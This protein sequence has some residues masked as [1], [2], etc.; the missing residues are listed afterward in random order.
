MRAILTDMGIV[1]NETLGRGKPVILLPGWLESWDGWRGTMEVLCDHYRTRALDFWGSGDC[2]RQSGSFTV[3]DCVEMVRQFCARF[4]LEQARALGH[5][6]GGTVSLRL[7]L[8]IPALWS[9]S[10]W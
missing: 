4:G 10:R 3:P 8:T 6:M 9:G 2:G 1:H 7:A 5:S